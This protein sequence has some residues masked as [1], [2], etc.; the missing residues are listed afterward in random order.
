[1]RFFEK[2]GLFRRPPVK[3]VQDIGKKPDMKGVQDTDDLKHVFGEEIV[4]AEVEQEDDKV[5]YESV[6]T[7][8]YFED[9]DDLEIAGNPELKETI[10]QNIIRAEKENHELY[11]KCAGNLGISVEEFKRRLQ[12]RVEEM[13]DG[14]DHFR[15]TRETT[16]KRVLFK[17]GRWK[18]QFEVG[19]SNGYFGPEC[20][21][22][23]EN[24]MFGFVDDP[25]SAKEQRPI[26]TFWSDG[27]NGESNRE[28]TIPPPAGVEHYGR[29][30]CKMKKDIALRKTTITFQDSLN[31]EAEYPP[32]PATKP[33]FTSLYFYDESILEQMVS[34]RKVDWCR[35][36]YV[37]GQVHDQLTARDI[38]SIHISKGNN[39]SRDDIKDVRAAVKAYNKANPDHQIELV[40]Y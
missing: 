19:E 15:A 22:K 33:H 7:R 40:I 26:Y 1:M 32:S 6:V 23:A 18:S 25:Q 14:S 36:S 5:E 27:P 34:S 31:T 21:S 11:E 3:P 28:G 30:H 29:V 2:L 10:R 35:S 16:L 9:W 24:D 4:A 12:R 17:D 20:R 39:M 37:E 38:E 8:K 13:V